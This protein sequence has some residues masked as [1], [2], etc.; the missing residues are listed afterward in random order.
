MRKHALIAVPIAAALAGGAGA[1]RNV[2][3]QPHP[4]SASASAYVA[5]AAGTATGAVKD[6]GVASARGSASDQGNANVKIGNGAVVAK[7]GRTSAQSATL[8]G[9]GRAVSTATTKA[10][11]LAGGLVEAKTTFVTADAAA[12]KR[13]L[14]GRIT[15]LAVAGKRLGKTR[16]R[17]T[18]RI[19]GAGRLKVLAPVKHGVAAMHLHLTADYG[20]YPAGMDIV[21]GVA[22][23]SAEDEVKPPQEQTTAKPK[24]KA[25][26]QQAKPPKR[27]KHRK[28]SAPL[29]GKGYVFPVY[30]KVEWSDTWGAARADTGTH[31]GDDIFGQFG[32]PVLAVHDGKLN[33]VG[34][35]PISGNRLWVKTP[36]GHSFFYAHL[37]AFS[38]MA[39]NGA[40]VKAGDVLGYVGST[41]DAETTPNHLHFEVHP[42]DGD[43]VNPTPFL[44]AWQSHN[45]IPNSTWLALYG[46]NPG[47]RP[48]Q[49]VQIRD[50]VA[51]T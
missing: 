33:R 36:G 32:T 6:R 12:G 41:G 50:F 16:R 31:E 25:A 38:A 17:H 23:A 19:P 7:R 5:S 26:K 30:G 13:K 42:F 45:D 4:A 43:A 35:L 20:D 47:A 29:T 8:E 27:K 15:G 40:K 34:T 39:R 37:S 11:S 1:A 3:D 18:Y 51:G 46:K 44:A 49:L 28:V 2:Q 10:V 24:Q 48:G 22:R 21:V 9:V 14:S